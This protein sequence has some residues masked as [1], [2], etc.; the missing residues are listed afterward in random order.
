MLRVIVALFTLMQQESAETD[1]G[2]RLVHH[3]RHENQHTK[4]LCLAERV[5]YDIIVIMKLFSL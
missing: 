5:N 4:A 1:G 3:N 2:R